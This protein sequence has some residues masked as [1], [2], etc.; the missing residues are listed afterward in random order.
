MGNMYKIPD[1]GDRTYE[2]LR[3]AFNFE[4]DPRGQMGYGTTPTEFDLLMELGQIF[5]MRDNLT[6]EQKEKIHNLAVGL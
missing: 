4:D 2:M 3:Q 6:A 1:K 5:Q